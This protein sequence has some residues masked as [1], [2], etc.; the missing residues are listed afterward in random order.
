M[1]ST[2]S[3]KLAISNIAFGEDQQAAL[4]CV[5]RSGL[6]GIVVAP[7]TL[8]GHTY[9]KLLTFLGGIV[10]TVLKRWGKM[11]KIILNDLAILG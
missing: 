9:R 7:P 1:K 10:R 3:M 5:Y 6:D 4:D 2:E 11:L 8:S